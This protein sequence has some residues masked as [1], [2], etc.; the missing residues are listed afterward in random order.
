MRLTVLGCS[1]SGPG[2][3]SPG[4]GY[5]LRAGDA[6][7]VLE[8]GNGALGA[9]ERE[10]DPFEL[11]AVL[12]SHLHADHCADMASLVVYRRYHP[13]PPYEPRDHR[14]PVYGP[15]NAPD[16]LA[17]A[18]AVSAEELAETDLSDVLDFRPLSAG[19]RADIA[20]C[21]T[22]AARVDHPCDAYAFRVEHGGRSLVFSG[23]TG[24]CERLVELARDADVLLCEASWPHVTPAWYEPP[25]GVHLSGRQAGEHAQA[26]GARRLLITHVP[27][28]FDGEELAKEARSGYDG[29]VELVTAGAS[30]EI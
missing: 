16:R 5:L 20:G 14:L 28:W 29:P 12:L 10:L 25:P 9:L 26:A 17:A 7:L 2:P 6:R 3:H 22:T 11:D 27:A 24:P 30:Y 21:A 18:Y 4:S 19:G 15:A 1:G 8:L 13:R 23:D